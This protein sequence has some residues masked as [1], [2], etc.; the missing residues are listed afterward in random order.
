MSTGHEADWFKRFPTG[1]T[2]Y[3]RRIDLAELVEPAV[4]RAIENGHTVESDPPA[5][6]TAAQRWTCTRCGD[7]ALDYHGNV[8]GGAVDRT[9]D[10]SVAFWAAS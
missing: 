9:C 1:G 8:Y 6:M 7:A 10:E 3:G 2:V 4:A 5:G